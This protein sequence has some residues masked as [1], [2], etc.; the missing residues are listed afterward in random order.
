MYLIASHFFSSEKYKGQ[1]ENLHCRGSHCTAAV[2]LFNKFSDS[3]RFNQVLIRL[4]RD[5]LYRL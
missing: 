2:I 1:S 3:M 4:L 5:R